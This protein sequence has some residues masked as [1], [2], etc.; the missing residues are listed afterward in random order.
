MS[1]ERH[2]ATRIQRCR[3][4]RFPGSISPCKVDQLASG[5]T[6]LSHERT[7]RPQ[8][9][10]GPWKNKLYEILTANARTPKR[11]RL[12]FFEEILDVRPSPLPPIRVARHLTLI[13]KTWTETVLDILCSQSRTLP[14]KVRTALVFDSRLRRSLGR[15]WRRSWEL[16]SSTSHSSAGPA[17]HPAALASRFRRC[18]PGLDEPLHRALL[19]DRKDCA[20][21]EASRCRR[22]RCPRT[23]RA[24]PFSA[25]RSRPYRLAPTP[26]Q[27]QTR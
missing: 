20:T 15:R 13:E 22:S 7:I 11:Q 21:P 8:P 24:P 19:A 26:L 1:G 10:I 6:E 4:I 9:E 16:L 27:D 25:K 23:L 2:S 5:A 18:L 12:T 14:S 17:F 3:L